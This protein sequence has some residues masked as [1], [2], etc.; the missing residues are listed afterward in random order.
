MKV[1]QNLYKKPNRLEPGFVLPT[2]SCT[3]ANLITLPWGLVQGRR[4]PHGNTQ[5]LETT[6]RNVTRNVCFLGSYLLGRAGVGDSL[7]LPPP[8]FRLQP[9]EAG[10]GLLWRAHSSAWQ[11]QET[12]GHP[13]I[14]ASRWSLQPAAFTVA[15]FLYGGLGVPG[16]MSQ[17]R[18]QKPS[19]RSH[20]E[21]LLCIFFITSKSLRLDPYSQRR[22]LNFTSKG[23]SVKGHADNF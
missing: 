23:K 13:G 5:G 15:D 9:F 1:C 20:R 6:T 14:A 16:Y 11:T 10:A 17:E 4:T 3:F 21:S 8:H 12:G 22:K 19:H 18:Q 2:F 7:F